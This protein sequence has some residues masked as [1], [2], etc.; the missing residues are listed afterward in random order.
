MAKIT[1]TVARKGVFSVKASDGTY[2]AEPITPDRLQKW[3]ET[4]NT[5]IGKGIKIPAPYAHYDQDGKAPSPVIL[6]KSSELIDPTTNKPIGW[7]SDLNAGFW[8]DFQVDGDELK[9]TLDVPD[10]DADKIGSTI[11]ET[12]IYVDPSY[13]DGNGDSYEEPLLHVA[14]VTHGRDMGQPNFEVD[15]SPSKVAMSFALSNEIG[16][17]DSSLQNAIE[18]LRLLGMNLPEDTNEENFIERIV[19]A[20]GQMAADKATAENDSVTTPPPGSEVKPPTVAMSKETNDKH[21]DKA[22]AF[23]MSHFLSDKKTSLVSRVNKLVENGQVS[24]DFADKTLYPRIE[25]VAMSLEDIPE[26]PSKGLPKTDLETLI[27]GLES[28]TKLTGELGDES[29]SDPP[30]GSTTHEH[31]LPEGDPNEVELSEEQMEGILSGSGNEI[32]TMAG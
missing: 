25:K 14:L 13:K 26:D 22:A 6:G 17:Q 18:T 3:A 24:K 29:T 9:A 12:S 28:G 27:D 20:G 30:E 10:K 8:E 11:K 2:R 4:A 21:T 23:L 19:V 1:K 32:G 16:A 15:G 31:I 7:R 5:M